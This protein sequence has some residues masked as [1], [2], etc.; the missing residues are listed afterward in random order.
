MSVVSSPSAHTHLE[1]RRA[2]SS[3]LSFAIIGCR[4]YPS[5]Y[6]GYE[7]LVRYLVRHLVSEGHH[8]TVYCREPLNGN[9]VWFADGARCVAT[10]G[11]DSKQ[12][13]TLTF[14][15]SSAFDASLR[16]YDAALVLNIANGYWMPL[17]RAAASV[18][19]DMATFAS[20]G[21]STG[22]HTDEHASSVI[23]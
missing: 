8:V 13:S 7:T 15:A 3:G 2:P 12:L 11:K 4:G 19:R 10:R 21:V 14:G 18:M 5:T 6:G 16:R 1:V 23:A 17:L 20:A 22:S 9:R